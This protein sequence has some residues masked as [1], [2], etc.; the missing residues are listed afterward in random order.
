MSEPSHA[1]LN[2]IERLR[3]T[4]GIVLD[5]LVRAVEAVEKRKA[6]KAAEEE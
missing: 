2:K 3:K 1:L 6:A 4:I 5:G